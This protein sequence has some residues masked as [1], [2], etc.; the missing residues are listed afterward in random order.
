MGFIV[1]EIQNLI[2]ISIDT[3]RMLWIGVD[4]KEPSADMMAEW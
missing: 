1:L 2:W 4:R 3:K